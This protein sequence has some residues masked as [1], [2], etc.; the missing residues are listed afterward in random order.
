[1]RIEKVAIFKM[2]AQKND[3][4]EEEYVVEGEVEM[5]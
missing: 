1:V 4:G 3:E 2:G 5:P